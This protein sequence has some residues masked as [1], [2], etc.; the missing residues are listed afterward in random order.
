VDAVEPLRTLAAAEPGMIGSDDAKVRGE[1]VLIGR[2]QIGSELRMEDQ[3]RATTASQADVRLHPAHVQELAPMRHRGPMLTPAAEGGQRRDS[4]RDAF[5]VARKLRTAVAR[6][7]GRSSI[8]WWCASGTTTASAC[9]ATARNSARS[10]SDMSSL[11][12]ARTTSTG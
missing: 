3:Q 11:A 5:R 4:Y 6:A 10:A 2:P 9:G 8:T 12:A 1:V 7:S